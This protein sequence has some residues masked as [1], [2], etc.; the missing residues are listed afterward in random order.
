MTEVCTVAVEAVKLLGQ[1]SICKYA[2][3]TWKT[4]T[5]GPVAI[6]NTGTHSLN[7]NVI[8]KSTSA[9][10][11]VTYR[12][13]QC[14]QPR[15]PPHQLQLRARSLW[16]QRIRHLKALPRLQGMQGALLYLLKRSGGPDS[17]SSTR[18]FVRLTEAG[19]ACREI[20]QA[21]ALQRVAG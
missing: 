15:V 19:Y 7:W 5:V 20:P 10:G 16:D 14:H 6:K 13:R 2:I 17:G 9:D 21:T 8:L 11:S 12:Q 3:E 4:T 1:P 18:L